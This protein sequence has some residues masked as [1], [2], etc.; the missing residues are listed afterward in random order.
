MRKTN[1]GSRRAGF[2]VIEV[3]ITLAIMAVGLLGVAKIQALAIGN[4][5]TVGSRALAAIHAAGMASA[6][7]ANKA[8]WAAGLAPVSVN[9]TVGSVTILSDATLN[10]Y[11]ANCETS[12]CTPAQM[13]AYDLK[14]WGLALTQQL[15]GSDGTIACVSTLGAAVECTI[16]VRWSERY[17]GVNP[18][19][20]DAA[21]QQATQ[22]IVLL[23]Q[24]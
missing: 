20:L 3:M 7:P 11:T 19:V 4:T 2:S 8:Y 5:K 12:S 16:T 22:S 21:K 23:V 10:A 6:M 15:P 1:A 13:A 14:V 17:I 24:P 18:G 9:V